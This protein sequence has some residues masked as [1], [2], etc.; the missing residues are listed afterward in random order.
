M[1]ETNGITLISLVITIIIML[2]LAAITISIAINGGLFGQANKA[3]DE[4]RGTALEKEM[5]VWK[6]EKKTADRVGLNTMSAESKI[7]ELVEKE[8]LTPEE[9]D[10]LITDEVYNGSSITIGGKTID[11][12][13]SGDL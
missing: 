9:R 4:V 10:E 7:D 8:L 11:F 5:L 3:A 12:N 1:K 13:T 6:T 2:I